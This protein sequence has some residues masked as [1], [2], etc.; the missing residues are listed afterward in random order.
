MLSS[1]FEAEVIEFHSDLK[2]SKKLKDKELL[3]LWD[4]LDRSLLDELI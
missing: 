4:Q 3:D 1:L 2:Q